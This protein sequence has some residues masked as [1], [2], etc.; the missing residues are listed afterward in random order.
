MID[1]DSG[2]CLGFELSACS[3]TPAIVSRVYIE[4]LRPRSYRNLST[5]TYHRQQWQ[6]PATAWLPDRTLLPTQPAP[7]EVEPVKPG[8]L[9]RVD[10]L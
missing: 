10:V 1:S 3:A 9:I 7:I 2:S 4:P 8:V 6:A 5:S